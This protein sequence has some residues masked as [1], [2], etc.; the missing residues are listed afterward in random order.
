M[1]ERFI[2]RGKEIKSVGFFGFGTSNRALYEHIGKRYS[3][4]EFILRL[5]GDIAYQEGFSKCFTSADSR[6]EINEDILFL[7][8]SVRRDCPEFAAAEAR[9]TILCS[10]V[11]FFFEMKKIPVF[12]VT[13]SDGKSTTVTLASLML[14]DTL[15]SFPASANIGEAM[16]SLIDRRD[17]LGTVAELSSFQLMGF[18]P[19]SER[20][21]ITNITENHLDWHK[22][23]YEYISAKENVLKR[24]EKRIFNLDSH[25]SSHFL[26]KY[27]AFALYSARLTYKEMKDGFIAE[28]YFSVEDGFVLASGERLF[29]TEDILLKGE[30]NLYN[31]LAA[32]ALTWE[33]ASKRSVLKTLRSFSGLSHRRALIGTFDGISFYDSSADSTPTRCA[34]TLSAMSEPTVLLLGGRGKRLSYSPLFPLPRTVKAIVITGENRDELRRA[35]FTER[36][37][38]YGKI[39]VFCAEDFEDAVIRAIE[40]ACSGDAVLLSPAATS[41]DCF[42]NY[43]HRANT[44]CE[45]VK[46]YYSAD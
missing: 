44:F 25:I 9:G 38:L 5:D 24:A 11:E 6:R 42:K 26:K 41:F 13:G 45:I 14:T 46:K 32:V 17:V 16:I 1:K 30:Y 8:P 37:I 33:I 35:L 4:V 7:S 12:S 31:A 43:K 3:G 20:A 21:L 28:N 34:K 15:G 23:F 10:D 18:A 40:C 27:P 36:D 39:P 19:K 22:S 2:F 29:P